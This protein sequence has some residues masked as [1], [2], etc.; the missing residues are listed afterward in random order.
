MTRLLVRDGDWFGAVV[1]LA[2]RAA[3]VAQPST[4]LAA[5]PE[6]GKVFDHLAPRPGRGGLPRHGRTPRHKGAAPPVTHRKD[7]RAMDIG[8]RTPTAKGLSDWFT[9]DV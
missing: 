8:P 7:Q 1:N 6:G 2:A 3:H 5:T 4:V 9:G